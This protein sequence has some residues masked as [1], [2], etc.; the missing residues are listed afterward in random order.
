MLVL[1]LKI[2]F[3]NL[4][5]GTMVSVMRNFAESILY[6]RDQLETSSSSAEILDILLGPYI[7]SKFPNYDLSR[8]SLFYVLQFF[9]FENELRVKILYLPQEVKYNIFEIFTFYLQEADI[10]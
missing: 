7:Q 9:C 8:S 5:S 10:S 2:F 3:F 4:F 6:G 1:N